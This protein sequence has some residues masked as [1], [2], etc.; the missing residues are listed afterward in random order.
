MEIHYEIYQIE[1]SNDEDNK[2]NRLFEELG[3]DVNEVDLQEQHYKKIFE[4]QL[5]PNTKR[6]FN[7]KLALEY[8][9]EV[10]NLNHPREFTGRSLSVSDIVKIQGKYYHCQRVGWKEIN[11][12]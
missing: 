8:L 6:R 3:D 4:G 2:P 12:V 5:R 10:F 9:F 7:Y 1:E 11:V